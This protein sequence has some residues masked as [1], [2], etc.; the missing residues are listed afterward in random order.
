MTNKNR[1]DVLAIRLVRKTSHITS[2]VAVKGSSFLNKLEN[3]TTNLIIDKT[4]SPDSRESVTIDAMIYDSF[5]QITPIHP[6]LP[7]LNQRPSVTVFAFLDPKGF[8]GG[9]ATLLC[10]GATLANEL[11]Y[12]FRVAQTTGYSKSTDVLD[13]LAKKGIVIESKRFSTLDLSRRSIH[14]YGY[15]PLHP[16][17]VVLVSAWW[18]AHIAAQLPLRRKF[19]YLIQDYEPI[20]YN[21]SDQ[22]VFADQTY[23]TEKFIPLMNTE[24]LYNF[25]KENGYKYIT[26]NATWFEPAPAPPVS[27]KK[28]KRKVNT[29]TLFLYGRPQVHR[30]LFYNAILAISQALQHEELQKFNWEIYSAGSSNIPDIKLGSGHIIKN[31]GKMDIDEYYQFAHTIDIAVSPMLA[32][33]PNYPTLELASLGS[34]VVTTKWKTKQNLDSYSPNILMAD[35]SVD[36]IADKIIEAALK[37]AREVKEGLSKTNVGDDWLKNLKEPI[38]AVAKK[39]SS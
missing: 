30:N 36:G 39:L 3:K 8:Y 1:L 31:K 22:S 32:P 16:D 28:V 27:R 25:Y 12:D 29:K 7:E 14:N 26:E 9:I 33:H 4:G 11:G 37:P 19:V 15:L 20:F 13:F 5:P 2:K 6:S 38:K 21:N 10:V 34:M 24:K 35:A 23:Y 18:D 17:D